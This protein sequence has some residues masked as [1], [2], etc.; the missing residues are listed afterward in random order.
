MR[1][2]APH[3]HSKCDGFP[4]G[5]ARLHAEIEILLSIAT[6]YSGK[7]DGRDVRASIRIEPRLHDGLVA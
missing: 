1:E 2:D 7:M 3:T 6:E 5:N 4:K